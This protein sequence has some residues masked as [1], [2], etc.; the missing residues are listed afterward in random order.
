MTSS[1]L[2]H[3]FGLEGYRTLATRFEKGKIILE[4][5][6]TRPP[7]CSGCARVDVVGR[8]RFVRDFKAPPIGRKPVVIRLAVP[9]V[10][11]RACGLARRVKVGFSR[12]SQNLLQYKYNLACS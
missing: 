8:G 10:E 6:S 9:R 3:G 2:Y 5:E 1:E 11:C 4:V 7:R 12:M